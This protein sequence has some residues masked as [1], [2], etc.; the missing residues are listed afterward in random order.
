MTFM[1]T[2]VLIVPPT[3]IIAFLVGGF[4][5]YRI[6]RKEARSGSIYFGLY[7]VYATSKLR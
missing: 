3:I 2:A 1:I 5:M 4:R 6:L 7:E